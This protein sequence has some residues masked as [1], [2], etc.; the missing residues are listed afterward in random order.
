MAQTYKRRKKLVNPGLQLRMSGVFVGLTALML[1]L[2][3]VLMTAEL[4]QVANLLPSDGVALLDESNGIVLKLVLVSAAVFLPLTLLVG[5]LST[6]R[7]AGPLY[8]FQRF[9][10]AVR[11]GESPE[12]FHLRDKDELHDLAALLNDATRPLRIQV[13]LQDLPD[14][15]ETGTGKTNNPA[16]PQA[17]EAA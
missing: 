10:E 11:D 5:I 1:G 3:F 12:D 16:Q 4:H 9:L 13:V 17:V 15:P 8:R 2:Q 14:A 7:I 6:F